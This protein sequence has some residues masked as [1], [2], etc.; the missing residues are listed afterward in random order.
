VE[1]PS[2]AMIAPDRMMDYPDDWPAISFR[3]G[4]SLEFAEPR[5]WG[6]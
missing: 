4:N 1:T 6:L 3:R 2:E 5:I